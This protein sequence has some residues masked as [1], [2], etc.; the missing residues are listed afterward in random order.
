MKQL[1]HIGIVCSTKFVVNALADRENR[2]ASETC[3]NN[4]KSLILQASATFLH[5]F[6]KSYTCQ[7]QPFIL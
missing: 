3:K 2:T 7:N 4:L 1:S 6:A 5:K